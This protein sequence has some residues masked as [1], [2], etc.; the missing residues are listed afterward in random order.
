MAKGYVFDEALVLCTKYMQ[1]FDV[2][3]KQI[4]DD[5][6]EKMVGEVIEGVPK[7]QTLTKQL[8]N[9]AHLYICKTVKHLHGNNKFLL[10]S[11]K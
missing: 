5:N 4:W 7:S 3:S 6:K 2:T 9:V 10:S 1:T 8:R 11:C